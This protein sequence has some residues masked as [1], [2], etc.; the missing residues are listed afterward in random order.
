MIRINMYDV[1]MLT[2]RLI[3]LLYE[4]WFLHNETV[5]IFIHIFSIREL[6]TEFV[7]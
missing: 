3:G 5:V 1:Y 4:L 2:L 6:F 7:K